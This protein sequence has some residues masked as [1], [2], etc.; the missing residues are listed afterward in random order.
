MENISI[1]CKLCGRVYTLIQDFIPCPYC[2]GIFKPDLNSCTCISSDIY[3]GIRSKI[4]PTKVDPN[5]PVHGTNICK[6][7]KL[8]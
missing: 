6:L 2:G 7:R 5:C 1:R 8:N 4:T 3:I